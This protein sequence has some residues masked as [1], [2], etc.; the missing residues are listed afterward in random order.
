M[1][2]DSKV[3]FSPQ[4]STGPSRRTILKGIAAGTAFS[5]LAQPAFA[6]N[7]LPPA[8]ARERDRE[9]L[10]EGWRH[11]L[12]DPA[13]AS[14]SA[15]DVSGWE[16][17]SIPHT[18]NA[19]D[20]LDDEPGFYRGPGWYRRSVKMTGKLKGKRV[21]LY[22]EGAFQVADVY[23][24]GDRV[25]GH[26]GGY[27][28]FS[29]EITDQLN[30]VKPGREAVIAVRVDNTQ[31]D[32]IPPYSGD[33]TFYGGLY[34]NVWLISTDEVHLDVLD[35]GSPGVWVSTP[36]A[37]GARAVVRVRGR[38]VNDAAR[39]KDATI[40][41]TV[42]D[43]AARTVSR[44]TARVDLAA[45]TSSD[46]SLDLPPIRDPR[47]WSPE[48]PYRYRVITVVDSEG[49]RDRVDSPLGVRWFSVDPSAGFFLNGSPY[50]LQG[51]NRHQ[52]QVGKGN[53]LTDAEHIRDMT[54]IKEMGVN[55]VRLAHYP[56][57]PAVLE[58]ADELGLV[59]WE[60]VPMVNRAIMSQA[61]IDNH[62]SNIRDM[63]RQHFNHPSI[64]VFGTMN[65]IL[66]RR[67]PAA[68][69]NYNAWTRDM[70]QQGEDLLRA[71]D[72]TRL[73]AM[74]GHN[75]ESYNSSGIADIPMI[76]GWNLYNG[77]YGGDVEGFGPFLD[78][79]HAR[80]PNRVIWVSEFGAD[81]DAR[82]H[83]LE[84]GNLPRLA[85]QA[86]YQEQSIEFQQFFLE[87]YLREIDARPWL[88]GVTY[89]SQFDF[90][91][92]SRTGSVPHVNTKGLML[93]DR[94]PK[95]VYHLMQAWRDVNVLH[96]AT[97]LWNH[98]AGIGPAGSTGFQAIE[99]LVTVYSNAPS[100][101]LR[102]AGASLGVKETDSIGYVSYRVPFRHGVNELS[103]TAT[104]ADGTPL[105]DDATVKFTYHAPTLAD[106]EVPFSRL[107]VNVGGIVQYTDPDGHVWIEDQAY[108]PGSWG[109]VAADFTAGFGWMK[110]NWVNG[111]DEDPL[112][113]TYRKGMSAYRFDVPDGSYRL[114][115]R[116][117]EITSAGDTGG[118]GTAVPAPD[119]VAVVP[120]GWRV[121]DV[122]VNGA[123]LETGLDLVAKVGQHRPYDV[124]TTVAVAGGAGIELSFAAQ[125]NQAIV[126]A[127]DVQRI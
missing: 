120:V 63:V 44:A 106:P 31:V 23:V 21:F 20:S 105:R 60:E 111:S 35:H 82:L 67:P 19:L 34:R 49:G 50:L 68:P 95:P 42:Q 37:D 55:V 59:I 89:W 79:T 104:A 2:E 32:D 124:S 52:D 112:Y 65:E 92:E 5:I 27:T 74:V 66:L 72:P 107:S 25:G 100:V 26:I 53:A 57:S 28:A 117:A 64:I 77:W 13:G 7:N 126:N 61:F 73:T 110:N 96:I 86:K 14:H 83:R 109:A 76:F 47:L 51:T 94:T 99:Q 4:A 75:A 10:N 123:P 24:D 122:G 118:D 36:E 3:T 15:A 33:W 48:S 84:P 70:L 58:A 101:E 9:L 8:A 114:T 6:Q 88:A 97:D 16:H 17:V 102:I 116:F 56:Q 38:V 22:F 54:L 119:G 69:A 85:G 91:S 80:F 29:V 18:W 43:A 93:S 71:E 12:G 45:G 39:R 113:Q 127:I 41:V 125:V 40:T 11:M 103:A 98:R 108:A 78:Q 115:L 46:F 121:F 1:R 62:L 90:G 81:S 87:T 30:R